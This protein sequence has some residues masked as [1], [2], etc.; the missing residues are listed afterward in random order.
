M[1]RGCTA[2]RPQG[3]GAPAGGGIAGVARDPSARRWAVAELVA[4]SAWTAELTYAGAFYIETYG[5]SE[6]SLG[7]LLAVGSVAFL[8]ATLSAHRVAR[9]FERRSLIVASGVAMGA[10]S[11]CSST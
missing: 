4:Y 2:P 6:S 11:P 5:V 10:G 9:R 8:L 1:R 3:E 7:F